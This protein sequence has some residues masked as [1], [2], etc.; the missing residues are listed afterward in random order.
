[1]TNQHQLS[2]KFIEELPCE[3][4]I[5]LAACITKPAIECQSLYLWLC[6]YYKSGEGYTSV[7]VDLNGTYWNIDRVRVLEE[8]FSRKV[9]RLMKPNYA[10]LFG[11]K[12]T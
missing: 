12:G 2:P 1:M 3:Q 4:C 5:I 10:I 6:S 11:K 7:G 8:R 9:D